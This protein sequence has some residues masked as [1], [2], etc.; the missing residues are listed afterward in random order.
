MR[1]YLRHEHPI[2]FAHR[3]S[4][5]LWPENTMVAFQGAVDLGYRYLE[6]DV[7]ADRE[8]TLYTFHDRTVDKLTDGT[9]PIRAKTGAEV[10][11]LDAAHWFDPGND[12]PL[13]GA[14]VTIPSLEEVLTT[15]PD[16]LLNVD[17]KGA[18]V[19]SLLPP[20]LVRLGAED[21]VLAGGFL[22]IRISSFRRRTGGRVATS[23]GPLETLAVWAAS[24]F[25]K[26]LRTPAD[27]LQVPEEARGLHVTDHK[28]V[29]AAHDGGKQ[30]HVWTVNESEAMNRVLDL[31][32]DGIVTDRPDVLNDVLERR[33]DR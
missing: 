15:F 5:E 9:G 26:A 8:G 13:R 12:Y 11:A 24:R 18:R 22:D 27:A 20:L 25:G 7:R 16:V 1:A 29:R 31:G 17:L 30:V 2:R 33:R 10:A 4:R 6:T 3:G 14:G 19:S 32:A 23:A 21:R 28:L